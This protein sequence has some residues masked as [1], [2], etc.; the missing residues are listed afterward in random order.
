MHEGSL[1]Y[2]TYPFVGICQVFGFLFIGYNQSFS[3]TPAVYSFH[4]GVLRISDNDDFET[5]LLLFTDNLMD[6]FNI[7]TCG[8]KNPDSALL[9]LLIYVL[10]YAVG[11]YDNAILLPESFYIV[12]G[13]D[14][15][16]IEGFYYL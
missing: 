14:A 12:N 7:G 13:L 6:T 10:A 1:G 2:R 16:F 4:F 8:I 11:P 5:F 3:I 15:F 9:E